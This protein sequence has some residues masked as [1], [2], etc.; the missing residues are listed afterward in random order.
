M[1]SFVP[2]ADIGSTIR[3]PRRRAAESIFM[4]DEVPLVSEL[5]LERFVDADQSRL[6]LSPV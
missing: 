4:I 1:S 6:A 5:K 2:K 3:S